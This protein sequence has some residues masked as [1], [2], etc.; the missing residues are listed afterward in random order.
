MS[1]FIPTR[2]DLSAADFAALFHHHIELAYGSPHGV[3][4]DR[5]TRITSKFY[6]LNAKFC[7]HFSNSHNVDC[8]LL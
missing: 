2:G 8:F 4:S 6:D 5:D 3:V 7:L 1:K